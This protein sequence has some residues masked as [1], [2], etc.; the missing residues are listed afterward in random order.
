MKEDKKIEQLLLNDSTYED[1]V[2]S[3]LEKEFLEEV[4]KGS[5]GRKKEVI[6]DIKLVPKGML[7]SREATYLVMNKTN[8]T[9]SY[10]NGI[11]AEGFLGDQNITREKFSSAQTDFF[12]S[13]DNYIKFL[14]VKV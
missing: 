12:I 1:L 9:K 4:E 6:T 3:K 8:R 2:N 7:F 14:K 13:G 11:Q 5:S 10:V